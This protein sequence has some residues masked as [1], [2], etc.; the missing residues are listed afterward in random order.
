MNGDMDELKKG[1]LGFVW[2]LLGLSF[3]EQQEE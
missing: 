3:S 2:F 1:E